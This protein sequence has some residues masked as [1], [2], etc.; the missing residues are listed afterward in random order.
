MSCRLI[1]PCSS[2]YFVTSSFFSRCRYFKPT[3]SVILV[4]SRLFSECFSFPGTPGFDSA[5]IGDGGF[6]CEKDL[7]PVDLLQIAVKDLAAA[8]DMTGRN[9]SALSTFRCAKS[10]PPP[11]SPIPISI[12]RFLTYLDL[13]G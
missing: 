12:S 9:T 8:A 1:V 10:L 5:T 2:A 13:E 4:S 7:G 11:P 6:S 3:V